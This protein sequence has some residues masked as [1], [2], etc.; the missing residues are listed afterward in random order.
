MW[1]PLTHER[2]VGPFFFD[3]GIITSSSLLGMLEND[4]LPQ[5]QQQNRI[6]ELDCVPVYFP[7]ILRGCTRVN[8]QVDR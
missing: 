6:L 1:C 8:F 7:H 2:L 5:A 3:E 4:S